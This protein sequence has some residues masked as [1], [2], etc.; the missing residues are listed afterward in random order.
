M[1]ARLILTTSCLLLLLAAGTSQAA[2]WEKLPPL[3]EPN[4]GCVVGSDMQR[5]YVIG[6]THWYG[7][8]KHWLRSAWAYTP[9]SKLWEPLDDLKEPVA[10]AVADMRLSPISR[11]ASFHFVGGSNGTNVRKSISTL[12]GKSVVSKEVLLPAHAVL[13]S[14]GIIGQRMILVGGTHDPAMLSHL[15]KNTWS[16]DLDSGEIR[17]LASHPGPAFG[18]AASAA[19]A[20]RLFVFGGATW[21]AGKENV[22]N[23]DAAYA[24]RLDEDKW[25]K[26][27]SLPYAVR[28]MSAAV[29]QYERPKNGLS[30]R[31]FIYLA[32]GFRNDIDGFTDEAFLYN[33]DKDEYLPAPP[34]P[35]KAMVALVQCDGY[36][37]C[38]GGEDKK[39]SRTDAFYRIKVEEL[40]PE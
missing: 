17:M 5:I 31:P 4:G 33:I 21:D 26:L 10:Y 18:I 14:G 40:M 15:S 24:L 8:T 22:V 27:H 30:V 9:A 34:L 25:Q 39:Q 28:G 7:Q 29:V 35:Y 38:L 1:N 23:L 2:G 13:S 19:T 20:G 6:G 11:P 3:P 36:V 12:K 32:G 16:M 37:Y